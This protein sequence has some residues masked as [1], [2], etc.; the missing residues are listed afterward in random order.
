MNPVG[1]E[2]L[3]FDPGGPILS[4]TRQGSSDHPRTM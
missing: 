2:N 3:F 1:I 4:T